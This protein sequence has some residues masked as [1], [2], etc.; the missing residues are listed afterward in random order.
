MSSLTGTVRFWCLLITY[1]FWKSSLSDIGVDRAIETIALSVKFDYN[2]YLSRV[3]FCPVISRRRVTFYFTVEHHSAHFVSGR[4]F[5]M[6]NHLRSICIG[7]DIKKR[8]INPN[9]R[10]MIIPK[11]YIW[12]F[13]K[14]LKL[15]YIWLQCFLDP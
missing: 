6:Y 11:R 7:I 9:G 10:Q 13:C 4:S 8:I 5:W 14:I 2:I 1:K 15:S 3:S 12:L